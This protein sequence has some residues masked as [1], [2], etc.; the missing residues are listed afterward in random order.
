V[1][2]PDFEYILG[3]DRLGVSS[4]P[5]LV[6]AQNGE[7]L[8]VNLDEVDEDWWATTMSTR[9]LDAI[10]YLETIENINMYEIDFST[11][12]QLEKSDRIFTSWLYGRPLVPST[13]DLKVI[14]L[15]TDKV[16]YGDAFP[17]E[18]HKVSLNTFN[19][20]IL[21]ETYAGLKAMTESKLTQCPKLD[22]RLI[23]PFSIVGPGQT[24][25][26]PIPQLIEKALNNEDIVI[27]NDGSEGVTFTHVKDLVRF[28][29]DANLFDP[30]IKADMH[31]N[32]IN[33]CRV[34]N[35]VSVRQLIEKIINKTES[36]SEIIP[37]VSESDDIFTNVQKTPQIRNLA[38]ITELLIPIEIILDEM[39]YEINPINS[40]A[41]LIVTSI[42]FDLNQGSIEIIGTAEPESTLAIWFGNGE[43]EI[44]TVDINGN[45]NTGHTF[46]YAI[47]IYPIEIKVTT[48]DSIQY[49]SKVIEVPL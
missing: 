30:S 22:L 26:A 25:D 13:T 9:N 6:Q 21:N 3:V 29:Q 28:L 23:R 4:V 48:K 36:T 37:S 14:Y 46:E 17:N 2:N 8:Q 19:K 18:F 27:Y 34:Q 40:Y 42:N 1:N 44:D 16:Y 11:L 33:F 7:W 32:I 12:N 39:I 24:A 41:D 31:T 38:K 15:S 10:F 5:E 45:F 47:D 35:Y 49:T 43:T 20:P